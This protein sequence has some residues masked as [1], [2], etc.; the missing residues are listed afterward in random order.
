MRISE[1]N[2]GVVIL[3]RYDVAVIGCGVI[4]AMTARELSKYK[5]KV[6]IIEKNNDAAAGASGANSGI[7]HAGFDAEPGSLKARLNV[8]GGRMMPAAADELGVRYRNNTSI[9]VG[10]DDNDRE[11]IVKLFDKGRKNGVEGLEIIEAKK[12]HE[13]E[14]SLSP[15]ITC[16]LYAPTGAVICPYSLNF[17]ACGN[18]M[19]NGCDF[20]REFE[21]KTIRYEGKY[22]INEEISA[23]RI[24]NAA[25]VYADKIADMAG[26]GGFS[27]T[28]RRGEYM[29]LDKK[30]GAVVNAAVFR[31]P[32]SM[33]KGVLVTPTADGNLLLG[34]TADD[35]SDREDTETTQ[36]GMEK[37]CV[38]VRKRIVNI[39]VGKTITSFSGLRAVGNTGDFIINIKNGFLNLAAIESPG[40][41]SS[42]AIAAEVVR[43]LKENGMKSE[44]KAAFDPIRKPSYWYSLL[45]KDAKNEVIK[46]NKAFGKIVCRCEGISEG[47]ITEAL[48]TNPKPVSVDGI[49]KRVRAGMGRCQGGFCMPSVMEL[50]SRE[51]GVRLEE[52]KKGN[53]NSGIV[54]GKLKAVK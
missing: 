54:C 42:P 41:S 39:P 14:P 32:T 49:K 35:I 50:I 31:V 15:D 9:V 6:C 5:L 29:L 26:C 38:D 7:V 2:R 47:E 30:C 11:N 36:A 17:A 51:T 48:H 19:D 34:P 23:D 45:G 33:G 13:L 20:I 52:V 37:I 53:G 21:V 27:I 44:K 40:L 12:A 28:P 25:G 10:Y 3:E 18:A 8:A 46:N 22:I 43:I 4:G 24:V 16:A 1:K